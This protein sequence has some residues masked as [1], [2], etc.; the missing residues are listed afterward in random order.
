MNVVVPCKGCEERKIG[1][2]A[3]CGKY[4]DF[5]KL[6]DEQNA[7]ERK[8]RS[9]EYC[10]LSGKEERDRFYDKMRHRKAYGC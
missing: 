9:R 8:E 3:R 6:K 1:C 10:P 4:L 5:R 2:H 7:Y